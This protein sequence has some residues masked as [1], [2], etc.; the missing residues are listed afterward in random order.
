M[1][2]GEEKNRGIFVT[3]G[4][5]CFDELVAA[6]TTA[7]FADRLTELGYRW[8]RVQVGRGTE[9]T[10]LG[11]TTVH[12][13]WFRFT[14]DIPSEMEK[15]A[16]VISHGGAGSVTEALALQKRLIV[17]VNESLMGNHQEEL[18]V[19]LHSRRH[20]I[21]AKPAD[22]SNAV[23]AIEH[24]DLEPYGTYDDSLF[25]ALVDAEM[26]RPRPACTLS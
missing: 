15:A 16:V 10:F 3:V 4:T 1:L 14:P 2:R 8:L 20:L 23:S 26:A 25:P 19:E 24:A 9:P 6:V 13:T 18:A 22:I 5:T 17:C 7:E 11:E 12:R 21:L